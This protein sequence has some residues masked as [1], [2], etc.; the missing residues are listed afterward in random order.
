MDFSQV[1]IKPVV[2]E[3]S[4]RG[5]GISKF[6]FV[7]NKKATKIDIKRA[8]KELYGINIKKVNNVAV[9][10]KARFGKNRSTISKRAEGKKVVVT[11]A[12]G[13]KFDFHK[14]KEV[15]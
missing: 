6:T 7:V 8:F 3:K 9:K 11:F 15:K 5:E 14:V 2:T 4:S 10:A 13:Q 1:L 12:E